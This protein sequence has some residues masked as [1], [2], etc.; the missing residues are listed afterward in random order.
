M[1]RCFGQPEKFGGDLHFETYEELVTAFAGGGLHPA[2]LKG[3]V[4]D[5][6]AEILVPARQYLKDNPGNFEKLKKIIEE[7]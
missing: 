5:N 6:I 4:A 1:L 3:G 7:Q 2:D